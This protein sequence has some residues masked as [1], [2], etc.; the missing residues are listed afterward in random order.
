MYKN[1]KV[2]YPD[3]FEVKTGFQQIRNMLQR[4][5]LNRKGAAMAMQTTFTDDFNVISRLTG[6]AAEMVYLLRFTGNF[7]AQDYY[8]L[9]DALLQIRVPGTFCEPETL[10][11]LRLS[12]I[13]ITDI[14]RY[15]NKLDD[16]NFPYLKSLTPESLPDQ[17]IVKKIESII[18][19]KSEIRDKASEKLFSIRKEIRSRI[20]GV[21]RRINQ[22]LATARREGIAQDD[23]ELTIRNGRLVIPLPASNKRKLNG[24]VHDT[25]ATGHT[26][27]VEPAEVFE[28]NNEIQNLRVEEKQEVARILVDLADFL[29]PFINDLLHY[30]SFL[31]EMD[32]IRAKALLAIEIGAVRPELIN[33]PMIQWRKAVHPLLMIALKQQGRK[34]VDQDIDLSGNQRIM[35]ISGPN[36]GGKSVCLK[37]AGLLQYMLQCGLLIPVSDDSKAGIFSKIFLEIGDE[38]S[39]ENDLSTYSS[40]LIHIRNFIENS[41]RNSLILIDEF[42]AGTEPQL[43]GA[44]AEASLEKLNEN[45]CFGI[46]TTHYTN[47]KLMADKFQ[48]VFNAAMLYDTQAMQPLFKLSPG[49]PGSS[50]AFEIAKKIGF[51][52]KVLINATSK[53]SQSQLDF[54][55]QLAQLEVDKKFIEQK[56][57]ELKVAD[58][59]L[60]SLV[61][62]YETLLKNLE[63][64]RNEML[65]EARNKAQ[66]ILEQ[67]NRMIENTIR[68]IK[69]SKADK[70]KTRALREKL[71]EEKTGLISD[72]SSLITET[73]TFT[74]APQDKEPLNKPG[75]KPGG[76]LKKGSFVRMEGQETIGKIE[77]IRGKQASVL[78]G[79]VKLR[80]NIE[81]LVPAT[82]AEIRSWEAGQRFSK[83]PVS[84][85]HQ[86]NDKMADFKMSIDIRGKKAD[87]AQEAIVRYIDQAI[88]LRV[89]EVRILHGKGDGVLRNILHAYLRDTPEVVRFEDESLER[90]GHGVTLVYFR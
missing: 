63:S 22:I 3:N 89:N 29:R 5:C 1:I 79:S 39:L 50:F 58:E 26:V 53:I 48:G 34:I 33:E 84:V 61:N 24:Y 69:E 52:E 74:I 35:V 18:D 40:H 21:D 71:E 86:L 6:T 37:T 81:K 7:P 60:S 73:K 31:G 90:G 12:L 75:G 44:M 9:S 4:Y 11:E 42:G 10:S 85:I 56:T 20:S 32:F 68:Q 64:Q 70:E 2:I 87:E 54:E 72:E 82:Y 45:G 38:Q 15:L 19:D 77:E 46:I 80:I 83:P 57:A 28:I 14:I 88:L 41:D 43:G 65:K 36:A 78:F 62:R 66:Q 51:P 30:Y 8:D 23:T 76:P 27:F 55:K 16:G 47:L 17:S 59:T 25:S 49:K 67:S 13:A